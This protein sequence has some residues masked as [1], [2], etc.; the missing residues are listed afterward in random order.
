MPSAWRR[1]MAV[2]SARA[3][4]STKKTSGSPSTSRAP[5]AT[6][7]VETTRRWRISTPAR[8][9]A[10]LE[11]E[12]HA[13]QRRDQPGRGRVV[14]ELLA[15]PGD[16]HVERLGRAVP[17]LVPDLVHDAVP[18]H[19]P[20]RLRRQQGQQVELLGRELQFLVA[21]PRP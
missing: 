10:G 18:G 20:A 1:T 19:G 17:V 6:A 8:P 15:E 3:S 2:A 4:R 12:A 9:S 13:P 21:P 5:S 14:A 7:T 11:P 16:V